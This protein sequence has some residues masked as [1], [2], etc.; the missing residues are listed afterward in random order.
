MIIQEETEEIVE[1][2]DDD[3]QQFQSDAFVNTM[4]K[5]IDMFVQQMTKIQSKGKHIALDTSVQ[6]SFINSI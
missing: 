2:E 4:E 5:S 3:E 6:V 1:D